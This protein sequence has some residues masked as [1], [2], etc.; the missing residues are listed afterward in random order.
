MLALCILHPHSMCSRHHAFISI[1]I[2]HLT[3]K[4]YSCN[5]CRS[6][7]WLAIVGKTIVQLDSNFIHQCFEIVTQDKTCNFC[8][9]IFF[10]L[11]LKQLSNVGNFE[12]AGY[13]CKRFQFDTPT[14]P[15]DMC[16][17]QVIY[18]RQYWE[19]YWLRL[20]FFEAQSVCSTCTS[21]FV[22]SS[23]QIESLVVSKLD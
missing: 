9:P 5:S 15:T 8:A 2:F 17:S 21:S 10:N 12:I 20:S 1:S 4:P 22:N 14:L 13:I 19:E 6:M 23:Q 16:F 11:S 7:E 3:V 18:I